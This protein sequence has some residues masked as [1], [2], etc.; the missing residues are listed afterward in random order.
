MVTEKLTISTIGVWLSIL[1]GVLVA[2][3]GLSGIFNPATYA[4]E[5]ANWA[6]QAV[7]QDIGNL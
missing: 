6:M 4:K 5:T 3:A 1:I 2:I 7:G